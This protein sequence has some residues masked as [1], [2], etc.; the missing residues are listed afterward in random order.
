[1]RK[2]LHSFQAT[3]CCRVRWM[4][5][6]LVLW[7]SWYCHRRCGSF[8]WG[9]V[10]LSNRWWCITCE[11][12]CCWQWRSLRWRGCALFG[13]IFGLNGWGI[14]GFLLLGNAFKKAI[15]RVGW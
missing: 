6:L 9:C 8:L 5:L 11:I 1:M 2:R 4:L 12:N 7:D 3:C 15:W 10:W 14:A 13:S